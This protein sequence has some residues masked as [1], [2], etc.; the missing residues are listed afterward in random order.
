VGSLSA[1]AQAEAHCRGPAAP[2][3]PHR[4]QRDAGLA[5]SRSWAGAGIAKYEWQLTDGTTAV[6]ATQKRTYAKPGTYSEILKVTD[7]E[8]RVDYDFA[9]V[10]V[11]DKDM[12][13]KVPSIHAV[14][15]PTQGIK[16]G[17]AV[18]FKVRTFN[19][20]DG[21]EVWNFGDGSAPVKVKSD[22]NVKPLARDGYA[23]T[24]HSFAK[25]GQYLVSVQRINAAG[26][27]ATA[28]L[29]VLVGMS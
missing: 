12:P 7:K 18:T 21:E 2:L 15:Y 13:K 17:D 16:P 19:T 4:R 26:I 5:G 27:T 1:A 6:G 10:Q 23:V 24:T 25:P 9:V 14:Y 29:H 11:V 22:G 3:C 8:G 20:T 28:R